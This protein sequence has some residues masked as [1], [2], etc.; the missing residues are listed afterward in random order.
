[1]SDS[2]LDLLAPP[3]SDTS[4]RMLGVAVGIV[5]NNKDPDG[6]GRVRVHFPWLDDNAES[7]WARI[8]SP[9]AGNAYGVFF[10]PEV[11]DEVLVAFQHG[12]PEAPVILGGLWNGKGKPPA[13]NSDGKNNMRV[14]KSRSGH[15]VRLDDT[16]G[17]EKIEIIDK[18]GANKI[19]IDSAAKT[20]TISADADVVIQSANGKIALSGATVEIKST[21]GEIALTSQ[22]AMTVK[23][24]GDLTIKGAAVNIN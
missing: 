15:L 4:G 12:R 13:D 11:G 16:D 17:K 23:A 3:A 7:F 14:I 10:L 19:V 6:F 8:A 2:L 20:V 21:T 1:M 24:T 5:T 22:A 9:M 18:S